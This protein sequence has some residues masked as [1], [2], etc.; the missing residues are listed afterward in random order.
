MNHNDLVNKLAEKLGWTEIRVAE[1]LKRTIDILN[2][3]LAKSN[4]ISIHHFGEF[5]TVKR[6]ER[7]SI[8]PVSQQRLLV[9]PQIYVRYK[10]DD[11]LKK[12]LNI[13]K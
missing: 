5:T 12:N 11:T 6:N 9:P 8:D 13:C 4:T 7:I 10:P 1:T 2:N 3:S